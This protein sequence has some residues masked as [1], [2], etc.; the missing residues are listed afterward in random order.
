MDRRFPIVW[1]QGIEVILIGHGREFPE[2]I[3]EVG[4]GIDAMS[5]TGHHDGV[6]DS[7]LIAC[8]GM[9]DEEPIF[10]ADGRRTDGVLD[11][12]IVDLDLTVIDPFGEAFPMGE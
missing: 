12:V 3:L 5:L 6:D 7:G 8:T 1:K 10:F 2:D 4:E 9:A 11:E